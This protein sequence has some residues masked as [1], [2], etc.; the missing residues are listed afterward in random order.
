MMVMIRLREQGPAVIQQEIQE[1]WTEILLR[2]DCLMEHEIAQT[3]DEI[4]K[5]K[6]KVGR[7]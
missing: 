7:K 1:L 5:N 3:Q 4:A 2:T 6:H